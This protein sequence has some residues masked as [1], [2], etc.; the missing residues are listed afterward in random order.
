MDNNQY[1]Q[2]RQNFIKP[3]QGNEIQSVKIPAITSELF[4]R[5]FDI[6]IVDPETTVPIVF[7]TAWKYILQFV[8]EQPSPE[9]AIDVCGLSLEYVTEYS[10]SDKPTNIVP[11]LIHKRMPIFIE[12]EGQRVSGASM[13]EELLTR[14]NAWRTVNLTEVLDKIEQ[15]TENE[16]RQTYGI[17]LMHSAAVLP[18]LAA[19][20]VA[21]IELA[22]ETH[23]TINMYSIFEI[24]VFEEDGSI[25]LTPLAYIKQG[26][27][28]DNK[29]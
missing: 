18:I 28:D 8:K 3:F 10:E 4:S 27:K 22:K 11:Q 7:S 13:N 26:I 17:Y 24:D 21:G 5:E 12:H 14:Y 1:E 29:K 20:Y 16:V 19:A 9:F 23:E 2:R 6:S 25:N 15:Q